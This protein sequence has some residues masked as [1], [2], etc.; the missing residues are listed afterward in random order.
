M[1]QDEKSLG[2]ITDTLASWI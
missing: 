1:R 2:F